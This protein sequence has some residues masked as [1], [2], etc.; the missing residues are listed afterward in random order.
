MKTIII[1]FS[2]ENIEFPNGKILGCEGIHNAVALKAILPENL[3]CKEINT[4]NMLFRNSEGEVVLSEEL[5]L[6]EN[7]VSCVLWE[8]LFCGNELSV[9]VQGVG[10]ENEEVSVID[11]TPVVEL[12]IE[13]SVDGERIKADND[14]HSI[15][16][17]LALIRERLAMLEILGGIDGVCLSDSKVNS[18]G[19]LLLTYSNGKTYNLGRVKGD[20]GKDGFNGQDGEN[21]YSPEK[22]VDYWT[23]SDKEAINADNIALISAELAKRAQLKPEFANDETECTDT[24]KLYV[25]PDGNI[26]AYMCVEKTEGGYTNLLPEAVDADKTTIYNGVG[27]KDGARL[28]SSGAVSELAGAF[29]TGFIPVK[30][31]DVFRFNGNYIKSDWDNYATANTSWYDESLSPIDIGNMSNFEA[32]TWTTDVV[33]NADGY[34][35]QFKIN[36]W[37]HLSNW[38]NVAYVRFTLIGSGDG[39]IITANEEIIE[40]TVVAEYA[41]NETGHAFVPADYES[42]IIELE[43]EFDKNSQTITANTQAIEAIDKRLTEAENK[44]VN[45]IKIPEFWRGAFERAAN[46]I[47]EKHAQFGV[48]AVSF[49]WTS[50]IHAYPYVET[51]VESGKRLGTVAKAIMDECSIPLFVSTGD[52]MS[53]SSWG[54]PSHIEEELLLARDYLAPVPY[55]QQALIMGNHDGAWGDN[56]NKQIPL[57]QVY[58]LIYRKPSMDL[59]RVSGGNGTYYYIDSVSQKTRFIFLNSNNTPDYEENSDGTAK[60][61]RFRNPT[62]GQTQ[63][64]WLIDVALKLPDSFDACIFSHEYETGDMSQL[65]AIVDAYN[66]GK[67]FNEVTYTD[68]ENPWRNSVISADFSQSSGKIIGVFTGHI[69]KDSTLETFESC[70]LVTITTSLGGDV[71]DVGAVAREVG[72]STEFAFDVV[73][74]DKTNGKIYCTR[75]GAGNDREIAHGTVS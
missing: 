20:D 55:N 36:N 33:E 70:P 2:G 64:M 57:E 21:G 73:T 59:S 9:Q 25:L 42:R 31:G 71:R 27:Y 68:F 45:E 61:D 72:T 12:E 11:K 47:K 8:Q 37:G 4:Y 34:I 1:D 28:S 44:P 40:P 48:N 58:N 69:H 29:L 30:V 15:P 5:F 13:R 43:N 26:Y 63:L 18:K 23:E 24:S 60:Y 14:S 67:T 53:Q 56:Y 6:D 54:S 49:V 75:V 74:I 7:S 17:Q 16:A 46:V 10:I 66:G 19:E 39:C 22:G 52:L 62:Y 38:K 65:S 32:D 35:T 41:W 50:D 3:I 51:N